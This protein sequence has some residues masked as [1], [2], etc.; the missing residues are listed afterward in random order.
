MTSLLTRLK[1]AT[2]PDRDLDLEIECLFYKRPARIHLHRVREYTASL[3]AVLSL[4]GEVLPGWSY[5]L[6][7]PSMNAMGDTLPARAQL[8]EVV[9]GDFGKTW[10]KRADGSSHCMIL[11]ALIA[12]LTAMGELD[13]E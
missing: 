6:D 4:I 13:D 3:D 10:I 9:D 12:L 5:H 2:G 1:E 7:S 11:A 8:R